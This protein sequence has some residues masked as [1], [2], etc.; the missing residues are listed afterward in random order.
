MKR[1]QTSTN[2][3]F[4]PYILAE[5]CLYVGHC[6]AND[7]GTDLIS[8]CFIPLKLHQST[9]SQIMNPNVLEQSFK[10]ESY[11]KIDCIVCLCVLFTS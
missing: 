5:Q 2:K 6:S 9:Q 10:I 8:K 7:A 1:I 4:A 11:C 3:L